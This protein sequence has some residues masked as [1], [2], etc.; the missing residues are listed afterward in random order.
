MK[1]FIYAMHCKVQFDLSSMNCMTRFP[2]GNLAID[3]FYF[4]VW[5]Q[6]IV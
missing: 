3:H 6:Y 4:S 5:L 2:H 1:T